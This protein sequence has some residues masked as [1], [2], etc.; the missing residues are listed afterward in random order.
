MSIRKKIKTAEAYADISEA[1]LA[2]KIGMSPQSFSNRLKT[3]KY[4]KE[5]L[6]QIA[7]ALGAKYICYFEFPDGMKI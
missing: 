7:E 1:T 6:E 5:E 2:K 4:T 3:G